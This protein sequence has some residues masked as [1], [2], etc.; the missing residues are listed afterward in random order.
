MENF[1]E[2]WDSKIGTCK[3]S[4]YPPYSEKKIAMLGFLLKKRA[5]VSLKYLPHLVMLSRHRGYVR[6]QSHC[7]AKPRK[8]FRIHSELEEGKIKLR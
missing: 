1:K 5:G 3:K 6:F 4:R 7:P 8:N 2:F